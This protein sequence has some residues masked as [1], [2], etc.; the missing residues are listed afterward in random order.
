MMR[1]FR[2][3]LPEV[4]P[5]QSNQAID[6]CPSLGVIDAE[7]EYEYGVSGQK[8]EENEDM[9]GG[10]LRVSCD[11]LMQFYKT[12]RGDRGDGYDMYKQ[13]WYWKGQGVWTG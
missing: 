7:Y 1:R 8:E 2:S 10:M 9:Y 6:T 5:Q 4:D 13:S 12:A 3:C 11:C